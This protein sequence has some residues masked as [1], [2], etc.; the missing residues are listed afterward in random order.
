MSEALALSRRKLL[1]LLSHVAMATGLA[2]AYGFL[3]SLFA[4][5]LWVDDS[6][7]KR[8]QFVGPIGEFGLGE[9]LS[10]QSPVGEQVVITRRS[11]SGS[12]TDFLALSSTCPH[13][14]CQVHWEP[15]NQRFFCP[16]HNGAFS[17]DG[18]ATEGPPAQAGQRLPEY[19]LEVRQGHLFIQVPTRRLVADRGSVPGSDTPDGAPAGR[20][21]RLTRGRL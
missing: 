3:G 5:F 17:P 12:A 18:V 11:Q 7:S 8:W 21:T 13:L 4:R 19:P 1:T 10:Y 15:H 2:A 6:S 20:G 9:S 14:G 16:C